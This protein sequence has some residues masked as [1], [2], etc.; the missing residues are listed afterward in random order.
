MASTGTGGAATG[1]VVVPGRAGLPLLVVTGDGA[2][3]A[4]ELRP[5]SPVQATEG[6][7]KLVHNRAKLDVNDRMGR[8]SAVCQSAESLS[9]GC[10][11]VGL[12]TQVGRSLRVGTDPG[13]S[14]LEAVTSL[15]ATRGQGSCCTVLNMEKRFVALR[16]RV[17]A[18]YDNSDP[19][20]DFVHVGRVM[21]KCEELC[22][23]VGA[24]PTIALPAAL[25]HDIVNVPKNHP[26]R[27]EASRKAA[28]V[29]TPL[30]QEHGY[31]PE[32]IARIASAIVE[33]SFSRG[34][35]PSSL[36]SAVLQ[37]ADRLDALGA[38]G[39]MRTVTCGAKM[40]ARYYADSEPVDPKTRTLDDKSFTVDHLFVKLFHLA[41]RMNTEPAKKEADERT[42]FLRSFLAQLGREIVGD[43]S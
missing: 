13:K 43:Q 31:T 39:I 28:E 8:S 2:L 9:Q 20:H 33:H 5:A 10:L 35:L 26:D 3:P 12:A 41:E 25:L 29:A 32:E 6:T 4:C 16:E 7:S 42:A 40:G 34:L 30:L 11:N 27:T 19:G 21:A 15:F 36:E 24:D 17:R 22:A 14:S 1:V 38:V 18:T 23:K 37:D